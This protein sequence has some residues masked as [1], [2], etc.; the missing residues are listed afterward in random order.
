MDTVIVKL[1]DEQAG[2]IKPIVDSAEVMAMTLGQIVL[3]NDGSYRMR[4]GNLTYEQSLMLQ[5]LVIPDEV[6]E[7][8]GAW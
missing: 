7:F 8:V 3:F 4:V 5:G 6:G 1:T 2:L